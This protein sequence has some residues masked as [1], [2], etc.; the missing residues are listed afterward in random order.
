[1]KRVDITGKRFGRLVAIKRVETVTSSSGRKYSVWL[2]KCD[3]GRYKNVRLGN[4]R[5]GTVRSCGCLFSEE[6]SKAMKTRQLAGFNKTHGEADTRLYRVW[7]AMKRRCSN[8]HVAYYELYG[9]RGISVCDEWQAY[10]PFRDW[11]KE[12]GYRRG[13]TIDRIDC[14]GNYEPSNCRWATVQ[15]Q[16]RNRRNNM[17]Y[18]YQGKQYTVLEIANMVG[19]KPRTIQGRIERGWTID[20]VVETPLL[21]SNGKYFRKHIDKSRS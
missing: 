15:E 19:L 11:A 9:G 4:L 8:P 10:E 6:K 2:C 14:D 20:E 7:A 3:C 16:Q 5:Q 13:L 1:M 18:E 12:N 21:K 17:R